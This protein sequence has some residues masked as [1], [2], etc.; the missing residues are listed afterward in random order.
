MRAKNPRWKW[1]ALALGLGLSLVWPTIG[2]EAVTPTDSAANA[3]ARQSEESP[4]T[5]EYAAVEALE[6]KQTLAQP[7]A[8]GPLVASFIDGVWTV[9]E[10]APAADAVESDR[11]QSEPA[12][13][14][15]RVIDDLGSDVL[16]SKFF[17]GERGS[18]S[19]GDATREELA[20]AVRELVNEDAG[21]IDAPTARR[22][23]PNFSEGAAEN[24]PDSNS[25]QVLREASRELERVANRLEDQGLYDQADAVFALASSMRDRARLEVGRAYE[26]VFPVREPIRSFHFDGPG[27]ESWR[28]THVIYLSGEYTTEELKN[29]IERLDERLI[30]AGARSESEETLEGVHGEP[31][32]DEAPTNARSGDSN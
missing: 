16:R 3:E 26:A 32:A 10:N 22:R 9:R 12:K 4:A 21:I 23:A 8:T 13:A 27:F 5:T 1:L 15:M 11:D 7:A 25:R 18:E 19:A 24:L 6:S 28:P 31:S 14:I 30:G 20:K 17:G 29:E 2:G